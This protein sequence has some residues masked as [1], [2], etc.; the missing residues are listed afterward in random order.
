[1]P[2]QLIEKLAHLA[3]T[4]QLADFAP[5]EQQLEVHQLLGS[6]VGSATTDLNTIVG[7]DVS[8]F[9]DM[10]RRRSIGTVIVR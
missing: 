9:N 7:K 4:L 8:A 2:S 10:L 6:Q 1:M 5:T 3:D